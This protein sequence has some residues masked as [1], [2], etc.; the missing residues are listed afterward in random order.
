MLVVPSPQMLMHYKHEYFSNQLSAV[1]IISQNDNDGESYS[2][3]SQ[4]SLDI[5]FAYSSNR[6]VSNNKPR[7]YTT[8]LLSQYSSF[9]SP[10]KSIYLGLMANRYGSTYPAL[11]YLIDAAAHESTEAMN[12]IGLLYLKQQVDKDLAFKWFMRAYRFN[13]ISSLL[14]LGDHFADQGEN[15]K[16]IIF[17]K[18]YFDQTKNLL[19]ALKIAN[20]LTELNLTTQSIQ[21]L[22]YCAANGLHDAISSLLILLF[23]DVSTFGSFFHWLSIS[24]RFNIQSKDLP[25]FHFPS[26][27]RAN[28]TNDFSIPSL[29][30][31]RDQIQLPQPFVQTSSTR[32]LIQH[33]NPVQYNNF[34]IAETSDCIFSRGRKLIGPYPSNTKSQT[35]RLIFRYCSKNV[36]KRN[37][38]LA[39]TLLKR[40]NFQTPGGIFNS[41]LWLSKCKSHKYNHLVQCGFVCCLLNDYSSAFTFFKK[42][43]MLKRSFA[44]VM[45]GLILFHGLIQNQERDPEKGLFYF[46]SYPNDP[47]SLIYM[48]V[49]CNESHWIEQASEIMRD[50]KP[51]GVLYEDLGDVFYDGITVPKILGI[52]KL[53]YG[54]AMQKYEEDGQNTLKIIQ[55]LS[56]VVFLENSPA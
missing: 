2:N 19:A 35:L 40:L 43:A 54:V 56:N 45:C 34:W 39:S 12:F 13:S 8:S 31:I 52:A 15:L 41:D 46:S 49:T 1:E 44:C 5:N 9:N 3:F 17:Y 18:K 33:K 20:A 38:L 50:E 48:G 11:H 29:S 28:L 42:S 51:T 22:K 14:N 36:M 10:S 7:T 30:A 55:K 24:K 53:W 16:A 47:I 25:K 23:K 6:T 4:L 21:W 26:Y 32:N 37:L 27:L